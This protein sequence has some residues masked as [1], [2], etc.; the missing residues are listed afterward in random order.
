[1]MVIAEDELWACSCCKLEVC[2]EDLDLC[3]GCLKWVCDECL[4]CHSCHDGEPLSVQM[5]REFLQSYPDESLITM[6]RKW[7]EEKR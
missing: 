1:M 6:F 5:L 2:R 7:L 3:G 4:K